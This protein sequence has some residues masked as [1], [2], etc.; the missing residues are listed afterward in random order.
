MIQRIH[1]EKDSSYKRYGGLGVSIAERWY[2][3]SNFYYDSQQLDGWDEYDFLNPASSRDKLTLDK[4]K[5]QSNVLPC[6]KVYS[7]NTCCWISKSEQSEY[8]KTTKDFIVIHP[9]GHETIEHNMRKFARDYD[10]KGMRISE[11]VLGKR[12]SYK[13]YKFKP[14]EKC[15]D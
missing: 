14:M 5:Y 9:D 13:G 7:K 2:S 1:N 10:L 15:N 11:C 12:N 6:D 3:F 8:L 4:D